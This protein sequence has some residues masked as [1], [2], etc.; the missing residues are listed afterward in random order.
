MRKIIYVVGMSLGGAVGWYMGSQAG[1]IMTA[2]FSSV[3]GTAFGMYYAR[4][5]NNNYMS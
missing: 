3:V 5:I 1:G 2:Y 4:K